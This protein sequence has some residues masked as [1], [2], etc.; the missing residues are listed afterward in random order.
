MTDAVA[1]AAGATQVEEAKGAEEVAT[2]NPTPR[3]SEAPQ[4]RSLITRIRHWL[5][6]PFF[7][8][9]LGTE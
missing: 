2:V 4:A 7:W 3:S 6:R 1:D 8:S 9:R 5:L